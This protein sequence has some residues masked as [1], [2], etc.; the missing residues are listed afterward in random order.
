MTTLMMK[1]EFPA[2]LRVQRLQ[3]LTTLKCMISLDLQLLSELLA[4]APGL[5]V[6]CNRAAAYEDEEKQRKPR[7][8]RGGGAG[9]MGTGCVVFLYTNVF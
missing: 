6:A 4:T 7:P 8:T 2:V 5:T 3:N 1:K 9:I